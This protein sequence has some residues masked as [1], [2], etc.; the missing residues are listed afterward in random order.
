MTDNPAAPCSCCGA[1]PSQ[2]FSE[3]FDFPVCRACGILQH[4]A[5]ERIAQMVRPMKWS[6]PEKFEDE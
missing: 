6:A 2:P 3:N 1:T 4:Q 5:L